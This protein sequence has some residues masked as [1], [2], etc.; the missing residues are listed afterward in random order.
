MLEN[1]IVSASSD[2]T[3]R[4]WKFEIIF[5]PNRSKPTVRLEDSIVLLGHSSDVYCVQI[6]TQYIVSGSADSN[7]IVWNLQGELLFRLTGHLG[8]VRNLYM[9]DFKLVSGGDAK[10][11][12]IWDYKVKIL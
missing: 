11:I 4:L 7:I 8:V 5:E 9:D 2:S 3:L 10:K 1:K 12:M 6:N